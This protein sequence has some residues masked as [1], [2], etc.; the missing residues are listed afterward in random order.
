MSWK[1]TLLDASYRDVPVQLLD[2]TLAARRAL[3]QHGM[4]YRD[5]DTVEDLGREARRFELQAV[6]F[7]DA[8]EAALQA[9]LRALEAPGEATLIH[10]VYGSVTVLPEQWQVRHNAERPDYAEVAM[11]LVEAVEDPQF[12]GRVFQS[13]EGA[14]AAGVD[15]GIDWQDRL[16]DLLSR[17]DSLAAQVQALIGAGWVSL[18]EHLLGLPGIGLRLAQLRSQTLGVLSS[19]AGMTGAAVPS[20][21]PVGVPARVPTDMADLIE[22][23]MP[24]TATGGADAPRLLTGAALPNQVPGAG[25]LPGIA[26]RAWA[27]VLAAARSASTPQLAATAQDGGLDVPQG[28]PADPVAAQGLALVTL[29]ATQQALSVAGITAEVLDAERATPTLTP[30]QVDLLAGRA[31]ALL[32]GAALLHRRLYAV[33]P[34]LDVIE[35]MRNIAALLQAAARGVIVARPPLVDRAAASAACLRLLAHRWY[36]DHR[37]APELLRLNPTLRTPYDIE[38]GEVL[39]AYAQ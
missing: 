28:L 3:A 32:E 38:A 12:F 36:G 27:T 11:T 39:R 24:R 18:A 2:D 14:L 1:D 5:G 15:D 19:L 23:S 9:L 7:G 8:Y 20:F 35:P 13:A 31:R 4:P 30:T 29:A 10:P 22:A 17:V 6:C 37:R 25:D 16:R 34:A 21:D 26:Q 33:E